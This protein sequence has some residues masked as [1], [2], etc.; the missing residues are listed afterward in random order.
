MPRGA[1]LGSATLRAGGCG[2]SG[3]SGCKRIAP[4]P[5]RALAQRAE[6][7]GGTARG[8]RWRPGRP[9]PHLC[10][11]CEISSPSRG[12]IRPDPPDP[13]PRDT[14]GRRS[15]EPYAAAARSARR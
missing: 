9:F 4:Q 1:P 14:D 5:G 3:S 2:F 8:G 11:H 13:Y 12:P 10:R 6:W 7:R 15:A